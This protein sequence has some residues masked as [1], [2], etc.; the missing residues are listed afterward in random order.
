MEASKRKHSFTLAIHKI[1]K[2]ATTLGDE[3]PAASPL[4]N[5]DSAH[6]G[7]SSSSSSSSSPGSSVRASHSERGADRPRLNLDLRGIASAGTSP[8]STNSLNPRCP[9]C[10]NTNVVKF[11]HWVVLDSYVY[12]CPAERRVPS[13]LSSTSRSE[14]G[15]GE[16]GRVFSIPC[17]WLFVWNRRV[18]DNDVTCPNPQCGAPRKCLRIEERGQ[19][20]GY[21]CTRCQHWR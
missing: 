12:L 5:R 14:E 7:T 8:T 19:K 3:P 20:L 13:R 4:S 16:K 17:A 2:P 18:T 1:K 15:D 9:L 6:T 21:Y 10:G 11:K